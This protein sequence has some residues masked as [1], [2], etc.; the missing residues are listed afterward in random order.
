ME[1]SMTAGLHS[2]RC[3]Y[4]EVYELERAG[5]DS[6]RCTSCKGSLGAELLGML[7]EIRTLPDA[8]GTHPCECGHPEMCRLPDG[9]FHCPSCGA[10]VLPI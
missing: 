1:D 10:E 4:C 8:L 9:V 2:I 6:A 7:R 3:P 5:D